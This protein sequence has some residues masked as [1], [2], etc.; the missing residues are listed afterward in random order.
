VEATAEERLLVAFPGARM[1]GTGALMTPTR[2]VS[3]PYELNGR[4]A[5]K[6]RTRDALVAAARDLVAQG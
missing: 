4:T 6:R 2:Y 1:I 3:I 5:Q